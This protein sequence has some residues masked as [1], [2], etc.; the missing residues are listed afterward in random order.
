MYEDLQKKLSLGFFVV[1]CVLAIVGIISIVTV[2]G[3]K[4]EKGEHGDKGDQGFPGVDGKSLLSP[5]EID[6]EKQR[7]TMNKN[8]NYFIG[9]DGKIRINTLCIGSNSEDQAGTNCIDAAALRTIIN[10]AK[11]TKITTPPVN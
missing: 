9:V 5:F 1:G 7:V 4:G 11:I 2:K 6:T 10:N 3:P 8:N